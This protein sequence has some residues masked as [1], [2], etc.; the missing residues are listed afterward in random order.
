MVYNPNELRSLAAESSCVQ[1]VYEWA[2]CEMPAIDN[3][4]KEEDCDTCPEHDCF[5]QQLNEMQ[6]PGS[7]VI[8]NLVLDQI[9]YHMKWILKQVTDWICYHHRKNFFH[10]DPASPL[11]EYLPKLIWKSVRWGGRSI[12]YKATAKN[13]LADSIFNPMEK[14]RF[15]CTY[16]FPKEVW[17]LRDTAK[18]AIDWCFETEPLLVYWSKYLVNQLDTIPVPAKDSIE[19][20][21]F[22]K[23]L[24]EYDLW[25]PIKYFLEKSNSSARLL[26]CKKVV[27]HKYGKY[28]KKLLALLNE[29][30]KSSV[31]QANCKKIIKNYHEHVDLEGIRQFYTELKGKLNFKNFALIIKKLAYWS[32]INSDYFDAL[33]PLLMEIWNDAS[34]ERKRLV[35]SSGWRS[36]I[37]RRLDYVIMGEKVVEYFYDRDQFRNPFVFI[38]ALAE[39]DEPRNF[40][41]SNFDWLVIWQPFASV[42]ELID[43]FQV[44][45]EDVEEL[46]KD[47]RQSDIMERILITY[48]HCGGFDE[49]CSL[50]SF[51]YSDDEANRIA[52]QREFL[53]DHSD[54]LSFAFKRIEI[55]WKIIYEF[56]N[57][58]FRDTDDGL[59]SSYTT[60]LMQYVLEKRMDVLMEM[61]NREEAN[62]I[63]EC[64]ETFVPHHDDLSRAKETCIESLFEYLHNRGYFFK[65]TQFEK[66][67]IWCYGS[68]T[69]V[70]EFKEKINVS[71][72]FIAMLERCVNWYTFNVC[73]SMEEFLH[74]YYP[75]ES[76]R[77][78]FK[79]EMIYSYGE[80]EKIEAL[81]KE[82]KYRRRS[83]MLNWFFDKD[84]Y[85]IKE[86]TRMCTCKFVKS[87]VYG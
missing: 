38:R 28:Q 51:C 16:C 36:R 64:I 71:K 62:S 70:A 25:Q 43:E 33:T 56:V 30:E 42:L 86:F 78:A 18:V 41:K 32:M 39:V 21:M 17:N 4:K 67:L 35:V 61:M 77:R 26:Q 60:Q 69:G 66:M 24:N 6:I 80:F 85:K 31:Y 63:V 7:P 10:D 58:V 55:D 48:L 23:A 12:D 65:E 83:R 76:E 27:S 46:K 50:V 57:K 49:F 40:L 68:E 19:E 3:W 45:S 84:D 13:V 29:C 87:V 53:M 9:E 1:L 82:R 8:P 14:Y 20:I 34:D 22:A 81:L 54:D 75:I 44:N 47:I 11:K 72:V 52:F 2:S 5:I 59:A 73:D 15:A 74:W 79:L 37:A